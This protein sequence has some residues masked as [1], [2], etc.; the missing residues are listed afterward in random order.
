MP[1]AI[2]LNPQN[3]KVDHNPTVQLGM[4]AAQASNFL[5]NL[6]AE[7]AA[8]LEQAIN[9]MLTEIDDATGL[10]LLK[11]AQLIENLLSG[12]AFTTSGDLLTDFTEWLANI[13]VNATAA[14]NAIIAFLETGDW[15]DLSAAWQDLFGTIFGTSNSLGLLG[16]IPAPAV[17][18]VIQN[19]QPVWDFPDAQAISGAGTQWSWDGSEDHTGAAGSGSAMVVANGVLQALKGV[20]GAVQSGQVVTPTAWVMWSGLTY[21]GSNPVQLQLIP[22]SQSGSVLVAGTPFEVAQVASPGSSSS[23]MELTG[24]YTVPSSGVAAVQLRLVVTGNATAGSV[25]WDDCQADVTG[26][27]LASLQN[28]LTTLSDDSAASTAAFGTFLTAVEAAITGYSSWSTFIAAVESAWNTYSTTESDLLSAEV[29]TVQQFFN[30]LLGIN[31]STGLMNATNVSSSLSLS[32]LQ[33]D[34]DTVLGWLGSP[35]GSTTTTALWTDVVNDIINPLNAIETQASNI[36][37]DIEQ[38]AV[39]GLTDVWDWLTGTPTPVSSTQVQAAAV[40]SAL[41]GGSTSLGSD[42]SAVHTTASTASTTASTASTNITNTWSWLFGTTTPT[43]S[44][45]VGATKVNNVLGGSSLGADV[46]SVHTTATNGSSW[47]TRLTNDLLVLSDVFHLVYAAGSPTDPPGTLSGGKPTWYSCWN[48]LL[49]LT[50]TVNSVSAPTDTAPTTGASITAASAAATT[51]GTNASI[52]ISSASTANTTAQAI[53][54]GIYQA[55]NGGATTGNPT[56]SVVTSLTAIP[57]TNIVGQTGAAVA[58]GAAGA[59]NAA[60]FSGATSAAISWSHTIATGDLGVLVFVAY[61]VDAGQSPTSAVT[62]G[63]TAMTMLQRETSSVSS[64]VGA[65]CLEAWWLKSPPSGSK[66]VTVTMG[67][68]SGNF[69]GLT[70]DSVSYSASKV[71]TVGPNTGG[72]STSLSMSAASTTG[73]MVAGAF[74]S[75]LTG[76]LPTLSAYS[77]TSRYNNHASGVAFVMGDAAGAS[78][79]AFSATSSVP[80]GYSGT[81]VQWAGITVELEN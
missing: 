22:Y 78:S 17:Q 6:P 26:G 68:G 30:T 31:T 38:S 2:D 18:N 46:T 77:Q 58:F 52:A 69:N 33:A 71:G 62:Y 50:G 57:A 16:G 3:L 72:G 49:G 55:S 15:S 19:L 56:S 61:Y 44:N 27:Y 35:S 29:F 81:N 10:N 8:A 11:W 60:A 80:A 51:A 9:T 12:T 32:S 13:N 63:G 59:G 70:G 53:T 14:W 42:V 40:S 25:W 7:V 66:T 47:A 5:T 23:W 45:Q 67:T 48:D 54:D 41:G 43:S 79:V 73:N 39:S 75:V 76:Q 24:T 21:T 34:F 1:R 36:V 20:P 4:S 37:G 65:A 74:A 64:G 28:D